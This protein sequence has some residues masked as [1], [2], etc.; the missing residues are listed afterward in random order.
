M[1]NVLNMVSEQTFEVQTNKIA[2][3]ISN[4]GGGTVDTEMSDTSTNAVQNKVIKEYVDTQ[5]GVTIIDGTYNLNQSQI[6]MDL[7][8]EQMFELCQKGLVI[9]KG[10]Y[11]DGSTKYKR[12][13]TIIRAE[14]NELENEQPSYCFI[15]A[16]ERDNVYKMEGAPNEQATLPTI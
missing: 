5:N 4:A 15:Y 11:I 3:A 14:Y 7:T 12:L 9:V 2:S 6:E 13:L 16:P 1:S 8:F 10:E